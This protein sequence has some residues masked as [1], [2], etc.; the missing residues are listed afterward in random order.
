MK[1]MCKKKLNNSSQTFIVFRLYNLE[2]SPHTVSTLRSGFL[3]IRYACYRYG[4]PTFNIYL[5]DKEFDEHFIR[6]NLHDAPSS[7]TT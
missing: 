3:K 5:T 1:V 4:T 7:P 6:V 2:K